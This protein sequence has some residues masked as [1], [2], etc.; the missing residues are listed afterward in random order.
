MYRNLIL[1]AVA[2]GALIGPTR[3]GSPGPPRATVTK[4]AHSDVV[5]RGKVTAVAADTVTAPWHYD[6]THKVPYKVATVAVATAFVGAEKLKEIKVAFEPPA[7]P[8][9]KEGAPWRVPDRPQL[10]EGQDVLLFL[11]KHPSTDFYVLPAS[12]SP[13]EIK[14]ERGK[15]EL[16]T[17]KRFV[18]AL[19]DPVKGLKSDKADV[20]VA[21]ATFL[22]I[23]YRVTG[24]LTRETDQITIP[25]EE[26]KLIFAAL[27]EADWST[28]P[29]PLGWKDDPVPHPLAAFQQLYLTEKD[30]WVEPLIAAAPGAPVLDY[31]QVM[32][33]AF[34]KW[35]AGPGKDYVIKR[36]V[37]KK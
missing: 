11:V 7:K 12:N 25:A 24:E 29:P 9:P 33:D 23:K 2:A 5:V 22:V 17:V 31:G 27:L 37:P 13:V 4:F 32:K 35:R 36:V 3:A 1:A 34:T 28:R 14:G 10:K 16:E 21:T 30:G 6:V 20:R 15:T 18:A 19:A 8:D 26:N